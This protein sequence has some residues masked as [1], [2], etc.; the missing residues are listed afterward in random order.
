M[1]IVEHLQRRANLFLA[2]VGV[3][4]VVVGIPCAYFA[5]QARVSHQWWV[6]RWLRF[7]W[8]AGAWAVCALPSVWLARRLLGCPRCKAQI[9][10]IKARKFEFPESCPNCGMDFREPLEVSALQ[11]P[12]NPFR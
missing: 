4:A 7:L 6:G 11:G 8:V 9:V 2:C 10:E 1:T 3:I 12:T 5:Y